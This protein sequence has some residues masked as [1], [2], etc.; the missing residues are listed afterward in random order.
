[1][2]I[3]LKN[4]CKKINTNTYTENMTTYITIKNQADAFEFIESQDWSSHYK[5][6]A[7]Y[8]WKLR[9]SPDTIVKRKKECCICYEKKPNRCFE[10]HD[11]KCCHSHLVCSLCCE[12]LDTCPFCRQ[13]WKPENVIILRVPL[14]ILN[15]VFN[16][17]DQEILGTLV[18]IL[19]LQNGG[20]SSTVI[21]QQEQNL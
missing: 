17:N 16:R 6:V 14:S 1:M 12:R 4:N 7:R 21:T 10:S 13:R 11:D 19:Q 15:D 9:Y 8:R 2:K 5:S 3:F 18:E 20:L